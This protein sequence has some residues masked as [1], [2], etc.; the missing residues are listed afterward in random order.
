MKK[1]TTFANLNGPYP[2]QLPPTPRDPPR[3]E[4]APMIYVCATMWHETQKEMLQMLTSI[5]R[6]VV[7]W[8]NKATILML[9]STI[10]TKNPLLKT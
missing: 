5:L 6:W 10:Y 9:K 2:T 8:I 4:P 3:R 1:L 7:N